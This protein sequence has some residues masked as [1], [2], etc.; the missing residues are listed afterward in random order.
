MNPFTLTLPCSSDVRSE[1]GA[2]VM[3]SARISA[4]L[5]NDAR[6]AVTVEYLVTPPVATE[7][8]ASRRSVPAKTSPAWPPLARTAANAVWSAGSSK[9][10]VAP[11]GVTRYL[12]C[13]VVVVGGG[14]SA[15][16]ADSKTVTSNGWD[17]PDIFI[18]SLGRSLS[19]TGA[20]L[21]ARF[22]YQS[23]APLYFCVH[24]IASARRT[25]SPMRGFV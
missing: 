8:F 3:P 5:R 14:A 10:S 1:S 2:F 6:S 9:A 24:V 19:A 25:A 17:C 21:C 20:C 11:V 23:Q 4:S 18:P 15:H 12:S 16:P 13:S 7:V 22:H